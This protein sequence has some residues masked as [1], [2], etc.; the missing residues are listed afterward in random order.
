MMNKVELGEVL[1]DHKS[2]CMEGRLEGEVIWRLGYY[3]I[4]TSLIGLR[5]GQDII[6]DIFNPRNTWLGV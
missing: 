2:V 6:K 3:K 5:E 4:N 1:S